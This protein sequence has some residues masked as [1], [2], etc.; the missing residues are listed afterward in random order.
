M[1]RIRKIDIHAHATPFPE[2]TER[3]FAEFSDR[4]LY[5]CDICHSFSTHHYTFN[6]YLGKIM[7]DKIIS[8]ENYYNFVRGN[9]IKLDKE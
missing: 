8:E 4:V 3:F 5:G 6:D 1:E 9:A 7:A 2:F